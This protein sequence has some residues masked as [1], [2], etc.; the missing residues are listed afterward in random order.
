MNFRI[1]RALMIKYWFVWSR[2]TFRM[3][4]IFFWPVMDLLVWGF[5]SVY[6]LKISNA[7]PAAVTFL[8]GAIILWNVLFRAQQVISVSYLDDLWCRNLLN[9]FAAPIRPYEYVAAAWMMGLLQSTI[10]VCLLGTI[11][12][13]IYSFK[14]TALGFGFIFLYVNL[15]FMGWSLGLLTIGLILR[16]GPPAEAL[17]W[18]LPF[19]IQPISAVFYPISILPTWL[20]P[21]S[22]LVPSSYV[23]EGMRE[24]LRT[25]HL[26]PHYAWCAFGLNIVYMALSAV[27]FKLCFE[28]ARKKGYLAKYAV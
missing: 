22:M 18:A 10:V 8:V 14:L 1:V 11:A 26:G 5:L 17:A 9:I 4:D 27:A 6:M 21:I 20:Q 12:A 23:F 7:V 19:L 28:E 16:W 3:L 2:S 13:A 25:S 15:L 24:V